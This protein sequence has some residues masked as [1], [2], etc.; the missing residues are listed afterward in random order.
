VL[1]IKIKKITELLNQKIAKHAIF[2]IVIVL[3]FFLALVSSVFAIDFE[4]LQGTFLQKSGSVSSSNFSAWQL[5]MVSIKDASANEKIKRV[6]EFFNRRIT[7]GDDQRIWGQADFWATPMDTLAKGMGDC[8]DFAI[9]KY[10]TL[11]NIGMPVSKL[12]LV[13]VKAKNGNSPGSGEQAH[14]VMAYYSSPDS[15]PMIMDNMI[16]EIRPASRRPDL[17]PIFSFNSEGIY[18]GGGG[19]ESQTDSAKLSR[20]QDLLQRAQAEGFH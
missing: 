16:T 9:A 12:R 6:N 3:A 17:Q 7:W 14:M 11:L 8:E 20:W 10:F 15:E 19:Q 2:F 4:K 13:Y 18:S 5:M 1:I